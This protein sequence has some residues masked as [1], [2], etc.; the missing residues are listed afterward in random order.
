MT[1]DTEELDVLGPIDYLVVEF[2]AG[3]S[4]FS[5]DMARELEA[6]AEAGTIRIL[7]VL[8]LVKDADGQFEALELE[9]VSDRA[10]LAAIE[11]EM[12]EILAAEDVVHLAEAMDPGSVAGVLIWENCWV[13]PFAVA[14]RKSGGQ[15]IANGRIPTQAIIASLEADQAEQ[16]D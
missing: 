16:G 14:A 5:G 3:S 15:L 8:I 1:D 7:D 11:V 4:S 9:D 2:P 13:A 12:A 6:L 10:G